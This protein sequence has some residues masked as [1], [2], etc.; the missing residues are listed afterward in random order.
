MLLPQLPIMKILALCLI[1][2]LFNDFVGGVI[3]ALA[4]LFVKF[5]QL[6]VDLPNF[7]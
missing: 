2:I 6:I 7:F 5:G 1:A 3:T 4:N